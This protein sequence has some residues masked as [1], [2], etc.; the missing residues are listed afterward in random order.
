MKTCCVFGHRKIKDS[1]E[2]EKRIYEIAERLIKE[3]GV[4][5][6]LFGSKSEFD[7]LCHNVIS[8]LKDKYSEVRRIYVRSAF[9]YIDESYRKYLLEFYEDTY[10]PEKILNAGKASYVERN[11]EMINRSDFCIVYYCE[12]YT[13]PQRKKSQKNLLNA[14]PKSGTKIAYEY[15]LKKHKTIIN[16]GIQT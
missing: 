6:F 1:E 10:F 4:D 8:N 3:E 5:T 12:D 15:A 16:L 7:C 9:P 11:Q 13:P 2:L 14:V